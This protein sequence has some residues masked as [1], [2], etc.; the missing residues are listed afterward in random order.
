MLGETGP[1]STGRDTFLWMDVTRWI[2]RT[3]KNATGG[4][5]RPRPEPGA[6]VTLTGRP[7]SSNRPC[8]KC[9]NTRFGRT[10]T[11]CAGPGRSRSAQPIEAQRQTKAAHR[12]W[13]P[14]S[15]CSALWSHVPW[16][17]SSEQAVTSETSEK[18]PPSEPLL[19]APA[20]GPARYPAGS[21][22]DRR[23]RVVPDHA[24]TANHGHAWQRVPG[25]T[26]SAPK[27]LMSSVT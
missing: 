1:P 20:A 3:R 26:A 19:Y 7:R 4:Q 25:S 18:H 21:H 11:P 13:P 2:V 27:T 15:L 16:L 10:R 22:R 12:E 23:R 6:R 24:Q 17:Q 9:G 5:S 8:G 14:L